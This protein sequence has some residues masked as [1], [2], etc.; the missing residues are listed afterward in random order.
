MRKETR[1]WVPEYFCDICGEKPWGVVDNCTFCGNDICNKP[2]C[3]LDLVDRTDP[4]AKQ[5]HA[6]RECWDLGEEHRA[7]LKVAWNRFLGAAHGI[8]AAWQKACDDASQKEQA[9]TPE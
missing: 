1:Q 9:E 4:E 5:K 3:N 2:K 8:R 6:C 7:H